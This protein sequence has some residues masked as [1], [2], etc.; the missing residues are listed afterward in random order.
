MVD[1]T[2]KIY[3]FDVFEGQLASLVALLP[4]ALQLLLASLIVL[5]ADLSGYLR[6]QVGAGNVI[7]SSS[8]QQW[9]LLQVSFMQKSDASGAS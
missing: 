6:E 9:L 8:G 7:S 3:A 1:R 2:K 4:A 5:S